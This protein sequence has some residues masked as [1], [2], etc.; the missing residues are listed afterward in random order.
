MRILQACATHAESRIDAA[1]QPCYL[2]PEMIKPQ[3]LVVDDEPDALELVGFNLKRAGLEVVIA[4]DG[5]EA[6]RKA[7]TLLPSLIVLDV[8][9]PELDGLEVCKIL[10]RDHQTSGIPILMLTAK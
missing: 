1:M 9:L 4:S 6:L 8:M 3:I 10:R 5:A 2:S 7:R